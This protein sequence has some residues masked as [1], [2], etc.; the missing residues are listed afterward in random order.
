MLELSDQTSQLSREGGSEAARV[1]RLESQL[2]ECAVQAEAWQGALKQSAQ[3][4]DWAKVYIICLDV[5]VIYFLL[6]IQN[7]NPELS[8]LGPDPFQPINYRLSSRS[9]QF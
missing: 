8:I 9:V 3:R 4:S 2:Q 5:R 6:F 7:L 1:S